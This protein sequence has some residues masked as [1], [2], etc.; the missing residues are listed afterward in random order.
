VRGSGGWLERPFEDLKRSGRE[1]L[2]F[3]EPVL[4][5]QQ[6]GKVVERDR[7][8]RVLAAEQALLDRERSAVERVGAGGI[9]GPMCDR[10]EVVE[11]DRDLVVVRSEA[12][13]E[14]RER[15]LQKCVRLVV[16]TECVDDGGQGRAV[17]RDL[18]VL[19]SERPLSDL[20]G[21]AGGGF[22]CAVVAACVFQ[23]SEVARSVPTAGWS[24]PSAA[25]VISSAR[26]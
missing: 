26:R 9:A 18:G 17:G 24:P 3:I 23:G 11:R 15:V 12:V 14:A 1:F 21:A 2:G 6:G 7:D 16:A 19:G 5:D 8:V 10:R 4:V 25:S 20:D 22:G 13:L